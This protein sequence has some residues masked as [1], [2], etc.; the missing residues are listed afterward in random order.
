MNSFIFYSILL[1]MI[2]S[3]FIPS[4]YNYAY[5]S[6]IGRIFTIMLLLYFTKQNIFLG[7]IFITI[8]ITYS[9]PLYEGFTNVGKIKI[10]TDNTQ[11]SNIN[12]ENDV[13]NYF[14][15][16]YCPDSSKTKRWQNILNTASS[17]S[18]EYIIANYHMT[19][20]NSLC[21]GNGT[22]N[23]NYNVE[24]EQQEMQWNADSW[25]SNADLRAGNISGYDNLYY[26]VFTPIDACSQ[27]NNPSTYAY[28]TPQ[29]LLQNINT[30]ACSNDNI[31]NSATNV[32]NNFNLDM[33]TQQDGQYILNTNSWFGCNNS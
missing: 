28:S 29:C 10:L 18:D 8:V 32:S 7:L 13:Y 26:S 19:N 24:L 5:S 27:N 20:Y 1:F 22:Y 9:Y 15:N 23:N 25:F 2:I 31:I 12:N 21:N 30:F 11:P 4:I 6:F 3:I 17:S 16:Y 33:S 14:Y